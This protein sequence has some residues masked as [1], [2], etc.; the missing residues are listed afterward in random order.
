MTNT[1]NLPNDLSSLN[2]DAIDSMLPFDGKDVWIWYV[3]KEFKSH[4]HWTLTV[5][6]EVAGANKKLKAI[7]TNSELIDNWDDSLQQAVE[8]VLGANE[9]RLMELVE[10]D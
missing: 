9:E 8:I 4:G 5:S 3:S 6:I 10:S 7:T 2:V 1:I